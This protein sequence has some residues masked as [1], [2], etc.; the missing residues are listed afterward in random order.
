VA[1]PNPRH[2]DTM[3]PLAWII[4]LLLP[5]CAASG[6]GGLPTPALL[7]MG[8]LQRPASPN[9]ALAAPMGSDPAPEIVTPVFPVPVAQLHADVM[10]VAAEQPRTFL[11]AAYPAAHQAHFVARSALFNFPDLITAQATAAGPEHSTLVLYSRSVYGYGDLGV[12]RQRLNAWLAA[13]QTKI[14]HP[15]ER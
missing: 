1:P 11:A 8:H 9:T 14:N 12:N 4:G 6:A 10:A 7:D 5:A 3:S 13:L 15:D 2:A